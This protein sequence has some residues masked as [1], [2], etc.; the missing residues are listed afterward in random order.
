MLWGGGLFG[1]EGFI[2]AMF[3][4]AI[5]CAGGLI[6]HINAGVSAI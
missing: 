6:I 1:E 3:G 2:G 4:E 5:D